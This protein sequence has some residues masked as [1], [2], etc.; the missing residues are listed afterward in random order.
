[1][2]SSLPVRTAVVAVVGSL[3]IAG[4][5]GGGSSSSSSST[6]SY[7]VSVAVSGLSGTLVVAMDSGTLTFSADGTSTFSNTLPA[8][9]TYL[10]TVSAQPAAQY[11]TVNDG[12]GVVNADATATVTCNASPGGV[13]TG[14]SQDGNDSYVLMADEAGEFWLLDTNT[15]G[16]SY[17]YGGSLT[18]NGSGSG[19]SVSGTDSGEALAGTYSDNS[20][21]ATGTLSGTVDPRSTLTL[22]STVTTTPSTGTGIVLQASLALT[23][24]SWYSQGSSYAD[25][26]SDYTETITE[27][28]GTSDSIAFSINSAG[29]LYAQ[30]TGYS[31]CVVSGTVAPIASGYDMYSVQYTYTNCT[32]SPYTELNGLTYSGIGALVPANSNLNSS[33]AAQFIAVTATSLTTGYNYASLVLSAD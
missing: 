12:P 16:D 19:A 10:V 1:M 23:S 8:G 9:S 3:M 28:S 24:T 33:T 18:V 20:V 17:A 7:S 30:D 13:W 22:T 27:E 26:A 31:G 32:K 4:C 15:N 5:G 14:Q 25:V 11:C 29:D 6:Q 21:F 2:R